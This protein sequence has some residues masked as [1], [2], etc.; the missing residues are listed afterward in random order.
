MVERCDSAQHCS[1]WS[2]EQDCSVTSL[3]PS[4]RA[5]LPPLTVQQHSLQPAQVTVSVWIDSV[6]DISEL[7]GTIDLKFGLRTRWLDPRLT[8]HNL[9]VQFCVHYIYPHLKIPFDCLQVGQQEISEITLS[10]LIVSRY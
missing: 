9:K 7:E 3:P 2:D 4:Y 10:S 5:G 6:L 1:D 8:F